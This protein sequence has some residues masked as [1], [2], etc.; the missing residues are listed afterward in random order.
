M[1]SP[2]PREPRFATAPDPAWADWGDIGRRLHGLLST[3]M[4]GPVSDRAPGSVGDRPEPYVSADAAARPALDR[5]IPHLPRA[6]SSAA[7]PE[8]ALNNFER[9]LQALPDPA[10]VLAALGDDLHILEMLA[11]L[12]A[13]SQFLTEIL[14][15]NPGYL[16]LLTERTGIAHLKNPGR[17]LAE[18][19]TAT[20]PWLT[21][22]NG[23]AAYPAVLD[24]LRRYQQRELLRIG[25]CDLNGL[26]ALSAVTTQ[27]SYLAET[28]IQTALEVTT[29]QTG[30]SPAG[31][32][33]LALGKLGGGE[34]NYSSDVDLLFLVGEGYSEAHRRAYTRLGERLIAALTE[35][36]AEGFLYRVDMRLR[37]WG[38]VGPLAPTVNS[39]LRYLRQHARLWEKQALLRGR[40]IA[41]DELVGDALLARAEPLLFA[42][43][44][45]AVRAEVYGMKQLT[46]E[47]LR[48][49]GRIWGEVKLGE[50]SIRDVEFVAQYLQLAHGGAHPELRSG[51]TLA[52]LARLTDNGFLSFEDHR[53]L[54]EG[55][56]FLRTVEHYL[57]LLDYRQTHV[58]PEDAA[59]LRY[60]ARRLGFEGR[61]AGPDFVAQY[62][63]HSAAVRG[64]YLRH[65]AAPPAMARPRTTMNHDDRTRGTAMS[66][67]P[68]VSAL[69]RAH[70]E[71]MPADYR[72]I[73][74]PAE[75]ELHAEMAA[76][77]T[78]EQPVGVAAAAL[79]ADAAGAETIWR[80]TIVGYDYLG[81]L[82]LIGGLFFAYGFSIVDGNVH[83]Y[84]PDERAGSQRKIVDVFT[85]EPVRLSGELRA[86]PDLWQRYAADLTGLLRH[87]QARQPRVAQGELA[88][89]IAAT[90]RVNPSAPP[91]LPPVDITID[92][93]ASDAYTV[94]RIGGADTP[95][96]L[97]EFTNALA[98]NRVHIAQVFVTSAGDRVQDTLY[99]TDDRG[100]KIVAEPRQRELRAAT[101][102]VKH[103]T[104]LLPRSPNPE[105][106]LLHF[107]EYLGELFSR[108]SW[109]DELASLERPEVL[110]ALARLLGVSE[111][112]WDDFLRMQ[113][114]N[115]FPVVENVDTLAAG[116]S[117]A[118][119][120]VAL[121]VALENGQAGAGDWRDALNAFK[122]RE[123]FRIDMRHI[124]GHT[125]AYAD[126]ARELTDLAEVVLAAAVERCHAELAAQYGAPA[127]PA[128]Y[129][130]AALGKAGGRE[131]GFASDVE[132]MFVYEA[133]GDTAGPRVIDAAEFYEKLVVELG[134]AIRA[135]REGIFEIDLQL[136]PYG[137]A[138]SL[139]VSLEAFRR[140]FAADGPAW[141]YERQALV[142]LRP[143]AGDPGLGEL[144]ADLR[145]SFVYTATPFDVAAMRA[146]R[147]RQLRHL[148]T[149]GTINAKFS[150]G[151]LVDVEYIVQGL[152]VTHGHRDPALRVTNTA[153]AIAA[154][155]R[156]NIISD[157]NAA[158][159][160]GALVF[161]QQLINALRM[162]RGNNRDLAVPAPG[163]EEF[164]F[165]ARRLGYDSDPA[166]LSAALEGHIAW[167]QRL[168]A[169]LLG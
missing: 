53:I 27:L 153:D 69:A 140:Y 54:S 142:K 101:V 165:L 72:T 38:R 22:G 70:L 28:V 16:S 30:I 130:L 71:R 5:L 35:A 100:Q 42:S 84:E 108:P 47:H 136:R 149:P 77:L 66:L 168:S 55:Y 133:A 126:F 141:G 62:Q 91:T 17:F 58:L 162:V 50:G 160:A 93:A 156:A 74:E 7:S 114:A 18:A 2:S 57:Q 81:V 152:Q 32:A 61:A 106:A 3:S 97:Y 107:N 135:R 102:L 131:L 92:N 23:G 147:E 79:P 117:R 85:V 80:V 127:A 10:P 138:G 88:K 151:G 157:E 45:E 41:G 6:L 82:S 48:Q 116:R 139:A 129:C 95:G 122:D 67:D 68:P 51:N 146:L 59:D 164:A 49:T 167:V 163:G 119:L 132:L 75:I 105:S 90:L 124:L 155:A 148:V 158:R 94:L 56:T 37:P 63:Q 161:L 64:V 99:V 111:F 87:L 123:M 25:I 60:L 137:K 33:V 24:A 121:A 83:T 52:A 76:A 89:R 120:A 40:V 104:H 169:R 159:L 46:E 11:H 113:Y 13:G 19:R 78:A 44:P 21:G 112:L 39:Y 9:F 12:F 26:L 115:L 109:P 118:E 98:L 145:D 144:L 125:P 15:R 143:I 103:F 43:G 154:L 86:A 1:S 34:L 110:D 150:R 20:D 65:L 166:R 73:F 29:A 134:R 128:R 96:F 4:L 31:F 14:L 8:R 36:T